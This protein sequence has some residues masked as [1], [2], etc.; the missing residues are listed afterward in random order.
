MWLKFSIVNTVSH[1]IY[2]I[3]SNSPVL[4]YEVRSVSDKDIDGRLFGIE[5]FLYEEP[6]IIFD[7][8]IERLRSFSNIN[9]EEDGIL[10]ISIRSEDIL[11]HGPGFGRLAKVGIDKTGHL[12]IVQIPWNEPGAATPFVNAQEA[13]SGLTYE[14]GEPV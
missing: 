13:L 1:L 6:E 11:Q 7:T 3:G 4:W 9:V 14:V 5:L 2:Q 10:Y 12:S 8:C